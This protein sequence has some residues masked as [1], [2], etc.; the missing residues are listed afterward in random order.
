[1]LP[2]NLEIPLDEIIQEELWAP[3]RNL[4]F[5]EG[6]GRSI[7]QQ[8]NDPQHQITLNSC[9]I[10]VNIV[11]I[12]MCSIWL[13]SL[14]LPWLFY[15]FSERGKTQMNNPKVSIDIILACYGTITINSR[16]KKPKR[17]TLNL[18]CEQ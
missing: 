2:D 5:E 17:K 1:M 3:F 9:D 15:V 11:S 12:K 6:R 8:Q 7:K 13:L 18:I 16:P 4:Y 10:I 14:A